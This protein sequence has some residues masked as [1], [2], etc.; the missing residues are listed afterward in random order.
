MKTINELIF[1]SIMIHLLSKTNCVDIDKSVLEAASYVFRTLSHHHEFDTFPLKQFSETCVEQFV[2]F[3]S[4]QQT[5]DVKLAPIQSCRLDEHVK[6][7]QLL[8]FLQSKTPLQLM[9]LL[10]LANYVEC[11]LL[12]QLC[13]IRFACWMMT[14]PHAVMAPLFGFQLH[15]PH[16]DAIQNFV[17]SLSVSMEE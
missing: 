13:G 2:E 1:G 14:P 17:R 9:E 7:H 12:K 8:T 16:P 3:A 4:F 11:G 15:E 10:L 6:D 5:M